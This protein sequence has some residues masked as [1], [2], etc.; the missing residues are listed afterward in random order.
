ME[1][2]RESKK[3]SVE[4]TYNINQKLSFETS[5]YESYDDFLC[6]AQIECYKTIV[7]ENAKQETANNLI[8]F[9]YL[10]NDNNFNR[11]NYPRKSW[12][13]TFDSDQGDEISNDLAIFNWYIIKSFG[14]IDYDEESQPKNSNDKLINDELNKLLSIYENQIL[15]EEQINWLISQCAFRSAVIKINMFG[16]EK[17]SPSRNIKIYALSALTYEL[18]KSHSEIQC[19]S[20]S[21]IEEKLFLTDNLTQNQ[22]EN[23]LLSS[24]V[25]HKRKI[26]PKALLI[27]IGIILISS[28]VALGI[29]T[30]G[31]GL[32]FLAGIGAIG[33]TI[34]AYIASH[35]IICSIITAVS[36]LAA[37]S[38]TTAASIKLHKD[39]NYNKGIDE[40]KKGLE[41][42][43]PFINHNQQDEKSNF[44][45]NI[46]SATYKAATFNSNFSQQTNDEKDIQTPLISGQ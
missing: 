17:N 32:T 5:Q 23:G 33:K 10:I 29:F 26:W 41:K 9:G 13:F 42:G 11:N 20:P 22:G 40:I 7:E 34:A 31:I 36:G 28:T 3:I 38:I 27:A 16:N 15:T 2:A 18:N 21:E 43:I 44:R 12:K 25:P 37:L 46:D 39:K 30:G 45:Q 6:E 24:K 19:K 35:T 8:P 1:N 4:L 14:N